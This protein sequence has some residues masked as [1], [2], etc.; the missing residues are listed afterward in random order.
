M[1]ALMHPEAV[2]EVSSISL[3]EIDLRLRVLPYSAEPE[4]GLLCNLCV[5]LCAL[6]V[7]L[8]MAQS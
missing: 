7:N 1:E 5:F 4:K 6:R 2:R 3:S 8:R